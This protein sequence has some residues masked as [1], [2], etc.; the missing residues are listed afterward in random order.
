MKPSPVM[1]AISSRGPNTITPHILKPDIIA[2]GVSVVA[3]YSQEVS[4]SGLASNG[5]RVA[6]MVE[7]G[8]SMSCP[9]V[10]GIAGLLRNKYPDWNPNMVY[11]AIMTTGTQFRHHRDQI[12]THVL[13]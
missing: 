11:S 7:S 6:H 5:R 1:A 10:A 9:H 4:P 13:N 2:P 12:P 8:T 3:A